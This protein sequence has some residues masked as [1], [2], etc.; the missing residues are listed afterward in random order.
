MWTVEF[1]P[2]AAEEEA[3]L[4]IDMQ[5]RLARILA[6][7]REN[8]LLHLPR[9]WVKQLDGKLWELRVIG[10]DGIVR[11]IYVTV[12]GQRLV[13][14][15]VFVKKTQKTPRRVLDLAHQRAKEVA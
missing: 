6:V 12:T 1:L 7:I 3:A 11:A 13:I 15:H 10:R 14:V 9:D 4:S 8:G 2:A 5:A